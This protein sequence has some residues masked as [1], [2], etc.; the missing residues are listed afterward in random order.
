MGSN[1]SE[2]DLITS[3]DLPRIREDML[4]YINEQ[5]FSETFE[6]A[7]L[8]VVASI[9]QAKDD[10]EATHP[11]LENALRHWMRVATKEV[12]FWNRYAVFIHPEPENCQ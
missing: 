10:D 2:K 8:A 12:E 9:D 4:G 3:R 11:I 5:I 7:C 1:Q 6:A